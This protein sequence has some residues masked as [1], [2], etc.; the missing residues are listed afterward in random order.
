MLDLL[1]TYRQHRSAIAGISGLLLV[2]AVFETVALLLLVPIATAVATGNDEINRTVAGVTLQGDA[3]TLVWVAL[4]SVVL[5]LATRLTTV[6]F[7]TRLT[8]SVERQQRARLYRGFLGAS[9]ATQSAEP[10]GRFQWATNLTQGYAALLGVLLS[11]VKYILNL[12]TMLVAAVLVSPAGALSIL[13]IGVAL[14]FALQPLLRAAKRANRRMLKA[15]KAQN[16]TVA[17]SVVMAGQ[18]KAYGVAARY[19]RHL[20][21]M[22]NAVLHEKRT[23]QLLSGFVSPIYQAVA[24]I[25]ALGILAYATVRPVDVPALGAV[26]LLLLRSLSSAQGI[27][28][29]FVRYA[30]LLPVL[31][32]LEEWNTTYEM[33]QDESGSELIDRVDTLDIHDVSFTYPGA[34]A[35]LES[36]SVSLLPGDDLGV[37][38]PSGAGK[39]TLA[40]V[41]LRFRAPTAGTFKVNGL[42]ASNIAAESFR[43]E[44]AYVPQTPL[45]LRGTVHENIALYRDGISRD[46]AVDAARRAGVDA[47]ITTLPDGYDT[48]IGPDTHGF[49]GGQAQR[50][51]I[52]RALAGQPSLVVL[53]EPT[54]ALDVDSEELVTAALQGLP[55]HVIVVLIAHRMSTLRHCNRIVVLEDGRMTASG[56]A[57]EI[58]RDNAFFQRAVAAG[59]FSSSGS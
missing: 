31:D 37:V 39:S 19:W 38:G 36:V 8:V 20:M 3:G 18:I 54:S 42:D 13:A 26:A 44:V 32:N 10:P 12:A 47:W 15:M 56:S 2:G 7:Q 28:S 6:T 22:T 11:S 41:L 29:A 40:Q 9:W 17:E 58:L 45:I 4:V 5:G 46:R 50:L 49:S 14:Y 23:A 30:E 43:R 25:I 33:N 21:D 16:E 35:A 53:D 24:M 55:E 1:R 59:A 48:V 57:D 52:A 27:Q 51:S 34:D